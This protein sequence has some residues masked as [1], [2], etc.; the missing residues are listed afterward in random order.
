MT[1]WYK[2]CSYDAAQKR[3][4]HAAA[5]SRLRALAVQLRFPPASFDIR[6]NQGVIAVSGEITLHHEAVYLQ[7]AQSMIAGDSGILI[8]S[9]EGRR[10]F[11]G[12]PN[13]FAPLSLFDDIPALAN[14]VRLVL[15]PGSPDRSA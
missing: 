13:Q 1:D 12:G 9:C 5:R 6:S 4:F 2:S 3:S 7:V 15:S 8:C 11:T 10:D 14:R